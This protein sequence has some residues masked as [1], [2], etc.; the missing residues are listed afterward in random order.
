[1]IKKKFD[2]LTDERMNKF[3]KKPK[4]S[5]FL[6]FFKKAENPTNI[7]SMDSSVSVNQKIFTKSE[8]KKNI[9]YLRMLDFEKDET[10][11]T[12]LDNVNPIS[13][14]MKYLAY[15]VYIAG[16]LLYKNSLFS[17]KKM[18]LND[19][20]NKYKLQDILLNIIKCLCSGFII[21]VNITFI[22]LR[23]VSI[24][25]L[26]LLFIFIII[27]LLIDSGNDIYSHG[28]LNFYLFFIGLTIGFMIIVL[29]QIS[30]LMIISKKY[31]KSSIF[32]S[33]III[34][35]ICI[36]LF[37]KLLTKCNYWD[38]GIDSIQID[39]DKNK[40]SC[41]I[42]QP[43]IC[44]INAF[45]NLL[46]FS[47]MT[48]YK[49]E[50]QNDQSFI[51]I[52]NNYN[53]YY[54]TEFND[55]ITVLNFPLT[56]NEA[57][58][59]YNQHIFAKNIVENIKGDKVKDT[60][61]SE[62]FLVDENNKG[63][64]EMNIN[65]NK[66]L[67][68]ERKKLEKENN[69]IKNIIVIYFDTLSRAHFHRKFNTFSNLLTDLYNGKHANF[70][71]FEF[72]KYHNFDDIDSDFNTQPMFFGTDDIKSH[73]ENYKNIISILKQNGFITAQSF[74]KCSKDLLSL[75]PKSLYDEFDHENIAMFCDPS[76]YNLNPK[77][78]NIKGINSV[79][80]R[81]LF[82]L[83]SY[84]YVFEYGKLFWETYKDSKKFLRLGLFDGNERSGE[85]IK[86]LDD[87]L[88]DFILDLVNS[89]KFHKTVLFLV[90]SKGGI[91]SG[92]FESSKITEFISEMN[93]GAWFILLSKK[94]LDKQI[95]E[96]LSNNMQT[97]VTPYDIYNSL[98]SLAYN[99]FD[100]DCYGKMKYKNNKGNS[101]FLMINDYDRNCDRYPEI[102]IEAC[103]CIKY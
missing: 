19:C 67:I 89:G 65:P 66:T 74:N 40:Y 83:D 75:S 59:I 100:N 47:K 41:K 102:E 90:S 93:L 8:N 91:D 46:D 85:V 94:G 39:N 9:S 5:G 82:G 62:I 12:S 101:V 54:N 18:P 7:S 42:D 16:F 21:S 81:C 10:S 38:K 48:N 70:E 97:F 68:D 99:C 20:I 88:T 55:N 84:K 76:Y 71:S 2:D 31:K 80:K 52:L 27:L 79:F 32:I 44:Y 6:N 4:K 87:Y 50:L 49:C 63:K 61:N 69:D 36:Y 56:N 73:G 26:F 95:I 33:L 28:L 96:N 24:M 57:Y 98:L 37:Y 72:M 86:Y 58:S 34:I 29:I 25:H 13:S 103:K 51:E 15:I 64:I 22:F 78:T 3:A 43:Q 45:N 17:C 60:Q 77:T 30:I 14:K 1:M 11:D 35:I 92:I 23:L 53:L